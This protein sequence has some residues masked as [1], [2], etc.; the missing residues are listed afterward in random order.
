MNRYLFLSA[1]VLCHFITSAQN[2]SCG[3]TEIDTTAYNS[4]PWIANNQYLLDLVDSIGYGQMAIPKSAS[5]GFDP[6]AEYWIPVKVWIYNDDNG[7]GGITEEEVENSIRRLNEYFA[8][9][10]NNTGIVHLQTFI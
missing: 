5:G 8:G 10:V 2:V 1:F 4:R 9:K 3:S 7:D 6:M